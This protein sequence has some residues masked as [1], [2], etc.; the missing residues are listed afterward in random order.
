MIVPCCMSLLVKT[1]RGRG[2]EYFVHSSITYT[3]RLSLLPPPFVA[4][5]EE[6]S[7]PFSRIILLVF[8]HLRQCCTAQCAGPRI[9]L[10]RA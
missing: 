1:D 6:I 8:R 10:A 5:T 3:P 9:R 2:A 4:A 7:A